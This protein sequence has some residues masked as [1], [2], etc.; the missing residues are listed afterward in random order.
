MTVRSRFVGSTTARANAAEVWECAGRV[1]QTSD[2]FVR[3]H[4]TRSI[5]D[6]VLDD[7]DHLVAKSRAFLTSLHAESGNDSLSHILGRKSWSSSAPELII[8]DV[9]RLN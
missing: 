6:P 5:F 9:A 3:R 8:G 4:P 2:L 7:V 1:L